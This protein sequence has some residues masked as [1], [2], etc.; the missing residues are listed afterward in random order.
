MP[1]LEHDGATLFYELHGRSG[2]PLLLIQG[3]GVA[4]CGWRPQ[5]EALRASCRLLTFDNR[6]LGQSILLRNA[7]LSIEQM[8]GDAFALARAA[9]WDSCHVAGHSMGGVIAQRLAL[10]QPSFVRS[11]MLLCTVARGADASR[12]TLQKLWLGLRG[13]FGPRRARRRAF[14][15][16][17]LSPSEYATANLE[18]LAL[19]FA[20]CFGRD[21]ADQPSIVMRQLAAMARHDPRPELPKLRDTPALVVSAAQDI[22]T[23][24]RHGRELADL[25]TSARYIELPGAAHAAT[26]TRAVEINGLLLDWLQRAEARL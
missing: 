11:L 19:Q 12:L 9:G 14:L 1:T 16:M 23:P 21:L 13:Q 17:I 8:A 2:P 18:E 26:I 25:L 10:Q 3:V 22:I 20:D 7:T 4:G 24:A 15:K 6:G 5:V